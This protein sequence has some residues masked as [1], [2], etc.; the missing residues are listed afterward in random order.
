MR[1]LEA[2]VQQAL[3]EEAADLELPLTLWTRLEAQL[4]RAHEAAPVPAYA[5]AAMLDL[6]RSGDPRDL[7]LALLA[8]QE[9]DSFTLARRIEDLARHAG[10]AAPQEDILLP[11]LHEL[12]RQG[13]VR[14]RWRPG[15]RGIRRTYVV[16]ARGRRA[17]QLSRVAGWLAR[18]R[19]QRGTVPVRRVRCAKGS[20]SR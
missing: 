14:A 2:Q 16:P 20:G 13:L 9:M 3:Q 15:P 18:L 19:V 7:T 5:H 8:E 17:V 12:E 1:N 11:L 4:D 10:C 6:A